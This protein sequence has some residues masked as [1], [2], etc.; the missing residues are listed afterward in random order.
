MNALVN[1]GGSYLSQQIEK[2][3]LL[4]PQLEHWIIIVGCC[5][6]NVVFSEVISGQ[7]GGIYLL[8][9]N[10]ESFHRCLKL[11]EPLSIPDKFTFTAAIQAT[12][13]QTKQQAGFGSRGSKSQ[14]NRVQ[15]KERKCVCSSWNGQ[16]RSWLVC[17]W[18]SWLQERSVGIMS[19]DT[20]FGWGKKQ[21]VVSS[22]TF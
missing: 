11:Q 6:H 9:A 12:V 18:T 3:G 7:G 8:T 2:T 4:P 22:A 20:S 10:A 5:E 1:R 21:Q 17:L 14:V 19:I 13:F 16:F 15:D